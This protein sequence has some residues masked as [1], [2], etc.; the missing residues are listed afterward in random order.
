M[1][2]LS[3]IVIQKLLDAFFL[4]LDAA[5]EARR[6]LDRLLGR[7][8]EEPFEV[9]W[10]EEQEAAPPQKGNGQTGTDKT[11]PSIVTAPPAAAPVEQAVAQEPVVETQE[12]TMESA[13]KPAKKAA[14]KKTAKK[15]GKPKKRATGKRPKVPTEVQ[16]LAS[17]VKSGQL[18]KALGADDEVKSKRMLARVVYIL[19]C[20]EAADLGALTST[21]VAHVLTYG[22]DIDTFGTNISRAIRQGALGLVE[23]LPAKPRETKRYALTDAGR[24]VFGEKYGL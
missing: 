18:A 2:R 16:D 12:P 8:E 1:E 23:S 9:V 22:V 4:G 13:P 24:Q 14:P 3:T 7:P 21:E 6:R 11:S 10:P 5:D 20:A 17:K 19:G 15:T